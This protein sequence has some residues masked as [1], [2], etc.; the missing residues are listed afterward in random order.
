MIYSIL[1]IS[2][3]IA[4]LIFLIIANAKQHIDYLSELSTTYYVDDMTSQSVID[5]N[6][7]T[8]ISWQKR[9]SISFRNGASQLGKHA[10]IKLLLFLGVIAMITSL[11]NLWLLHQNLLYVLPISWLICSYLGYQW[12]LN[13]AQDK[14]EQAF[15]DALSIM[16]SSVSAGESLL[17]SIVFVGNKLDTVV[18]REF[19]TMGERI[20]IGEN[21]DNVLK[22]ACQR[23]PYVSFQFFVITLRANISRGGQ[24]KDII[25]KIS[26]LLFDNRALTQKKLTMTAEARASAKIVCAIPF[27]FLLVMRFLMTENY[28]YIMENENGRVVLYY[29]LVSETI[30]MAIIYRLLKSVK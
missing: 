25:A 15:P 4:A 26:R 22:Q 29:L 27:F 10:K 20:Q 9:L 6:L 7:L 17:H 13:R 11:V 19:K 12:L 2:F 30:G 23:L 21:V 16:V 8:N 5:L 28:Q 3:A 1:A 18:G 24:L 14:F